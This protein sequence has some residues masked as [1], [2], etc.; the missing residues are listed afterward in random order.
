MS[1]H[2]PCSESGTPLVSAECPVSWLGALLGLDQT[3]C[4]PP[5]LL[6]LAVFRR[7]LPRL[8]GDDRGGAGPWPQDTEETDHLLTLG[9]VASG[10]EAWNYHAHHAPIHGEA[11]NPEGGKA[12]RILEAWTLH[13]VR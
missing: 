7:S 8:G 6:C 5:P 3:L 1:S 12:K 10:W 2:P 9:V 11:K 4:L 13:G